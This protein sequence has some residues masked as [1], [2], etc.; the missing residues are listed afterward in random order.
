MGGRYR[1]YFLVRVLVRD[2]N[3]GWIRVDRGPVE[4]QTA[5]LGNCHLEQLVHCRHSAYRCQQSPSWTSLLRSMSSHK[6]R[7]KSANRDAV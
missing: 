6:V 5:H 2:T 1:R 7:K 4:C 3:G